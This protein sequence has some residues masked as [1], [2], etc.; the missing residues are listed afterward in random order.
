MASGFTM[1]PYTCKRDYG[2]GGKPP[3]APNSK[4]VKTSSPK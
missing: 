3:A 4:V 2:G 1:I